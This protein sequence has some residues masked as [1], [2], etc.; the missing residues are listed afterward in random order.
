MGK[1]TKLSYSTRL[2]IYELGQQE[3]RLGD[4]EIGRRLGVDHV[5]VAKYRK[6]KPEPDPIPPTAPETDEISGDTRSIS[7]PKTRIHTLEELIEYCKIDLN[8]WEV[9]RFVCNKWEMAAK[10]GDKDSP[11]VHVQPLF[12][13]KAFLKK[14][15]A[16]I[17]KRDLAKEFREEVAK[18]KPSFKPTPKPSDCDSE[19]LLEIS[20]M[21]HHF[22]AL[23][24]GK[25]TGGADYDLTIADKCWKSAVTN[26]INRTRAFRPKSVALLVGNDQQN[27]DNRAGTTEAGTPQHNDGRYQKVARASRMATVWAVYE[28]LKIAEEVSVIVIPGNHDPL[29]SWHLGEYLGA[30]F[31]DEKRVKIDN[32]PNRRKYF[33]FGANML[34]FTH[35]D[36]GKLEDY[37]KTMA[38]EQP[39]MWGR[40]QWREAHTG[41]KHHR[42]LIET[43]GATVRILPSLRPPCAW[44]AENHFV[45]A[46][47]A[48]EAYVW[49]KKEGLIGT[50]TYSE[51]R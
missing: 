30:W 8:A 24:W 13:I 16:A 48:A 29:S 12:Q 31:K 25:E 50:A 3:P 21:D 22:G 23:I 44:S 7:L 17:A 11:H 36:K 1:S 14:N 10:L 20:I 37:D 26:L 35:G 9:E 15:K 40:T 27:A 43:K 18:F 45:G 34:L 38:A 5:I 2:K 32:S 51:L 19:N 28:C 47:R 42:R 46:I 4:R 39:A 49:N 33:E 41:D 6:S